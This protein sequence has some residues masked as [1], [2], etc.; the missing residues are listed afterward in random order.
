MDK[1]K[2]LMER[3]AETDGLI[4]QIVYKLYGLTEGEI[5]IVKGSSAESQFDKFVLLKS[6]NLYVSS[7]L[8]AMKATRISFRAWSMR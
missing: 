8:L 2:P 3:I 7:F 6:Q 1:L 5:G 4:D